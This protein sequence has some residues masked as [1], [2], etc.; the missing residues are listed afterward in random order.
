VTDDQTSLTEPPPR[1]ILRSDSCIRVVVNESGDGPPLKKWRRS[2]PAV[3]LRQITSPK[4][5]G[6]LPGSVAQLLSYSPFPAVETGEDVCLLSSDSAAFSVSLSVEKPKEMIAEEADPKQ[7][8]KLSSEEA[9]SG[10][11]V[12]QVDDEKELMK[13]TTPMQ[14]VLTQ[15]SM[16]DES[17]VLPA[18]HL[19]EQSS[20]TISTISGLIASDSLDTSFRIHQECARSKPLEPKITIERM[21][22]RNLTDCLKIELEEDFKPDY[23]EDDK[24]DAAGSASVSGPH[25]TKSSSHSDV[26][27]STTSLMSTPF[28]VSP[29][30]SLFLPSYIGERDTLLFQPC[31]SAPESKYPTKSGRARVDA[32]EGTPK[33]FSRKGTNDSLDFPEICVPDLTDRSLSEAEEKSDVGTMDDLKSLDDIQFL[34]RLSQHVPR[35]PV[36]IPN[37]VPR[38]F[39]KASGC[40]K[41]LNL[42]SKFQ[43]VRNKQ[44]SSQVSL[45][46]STSSLSQDVPRSPVSISNPVADNLSSAKVPS[47]MERNLMLQTTSSPAIAVSKGKCEAEVSSDDMTGLEQLHKVEMDLPQNLVKVSDGSKPLNLGSR[48]QSVRNKQA[49]SQVSCSSSTSSLSQH[50]PQS[51]VSIPNPVAAKVPS[52]MERHLTLQ[53]TRSPAIA[54]SRGKCEAQISSVTGMTQLLEVEMDLPQVLHVAKTVIKGTSTLDVDQQRNS[55]RSVCDLSPG[56][57]SSTKTLYL[58]LSS[59]TSGSGRLMQS[60]AIQTDE[61]EKVCFSSEI[62]LDNQVHTISLL[63]INTEQQS[64][65]KSA[66][67]LHIESP[68]DNK[69]QS[70]PED[71]SVAKDLPE[72]I[73]LPTSTCAP[74][75]TTKSRILP[76]LPAATGNKGITEV[77]KLQT[78]PCPPFATTKSIISPR[79]PAATGNKSIFKKVVPEPILDGTQSPSLD[80]NS[81]PRKFRLKRP[82]KMSD[83]R[84]DAVSDAASP[85]FA[86]VPS[87]MERNLTLQ[88]TC[89]PAIAVSMGKCETDVSSDD[90]TGMKQLSEVE[91][92]L[93]QVLQSSPAMQVSVSVLRQSSKESGASEEILE[94]DG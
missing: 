29:A 42:E 53:T 65:S 24:Q 63:P 3:K 56:V 16:K 81:N 83:K 71:N 27:S 74:F 90:T 59:N 37:P 12:M 5:H 2:E 61:E 86:K 15:P 82:W 89:S 64:E 67:N 68:H 93:P 50:V 35:S 85:S 80:D 76:R 22:S 88:T 30:S 4:E 84:N 52:A 54:A 25:S 48:F 58:S 26:T 34:S 13:S 45:S 51:P 23:D 41:S 73:K 14:S 17:S 11:Q 7:D 94:G 31:P 79:I 21:I 20:S 49:T 77:V 6:K 44:A 91:M 9:S 19:I 43:Y 66:I 62:E 33:T 87:P 47:P 55:T 57:N 18:R 72:V 46:S 32:M 28:P 60:I 70:A 36:T 69:I 92:D 1:R 78:S 38:R 40:S 39:V 10:I 8:L 75:L